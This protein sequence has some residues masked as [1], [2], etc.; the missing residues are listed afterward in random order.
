MLVQCYFYKLEKEQTSAYR[1]AKTSESIED[2]RNHV[3]KNAF[4]KARVSKH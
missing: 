3:Y 4:N 2:K 1:K